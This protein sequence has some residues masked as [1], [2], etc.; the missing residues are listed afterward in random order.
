MG[1]AFL[2]DA[3]IRVGRVSKCNATHGHC[4]LSDLAEAALARII[5]WPVLRLSL[6]RW[7]DRSE[8]RRF[9]QG[10]CCRPASM[11]ALLRGIGNIPTVRKHFQDTLAPEVAGVAPVLFLH[12]E[13]TAGSSVMEYLR[14]QF[15]PDAVDDDPF[16]GAPGHLFC[17]VPADK[18]RYALIWGHQDLPALLRCQPPQRRVVAFFR[19]PHA[20][21]VSLYHFWRALRPEELERSPPHAGIIAARSRSLLGFL[22]SEEPEVAD[23]IDN[24]YA[25]RLAG[26]YRSHG[27]DAGDASLEAAAMA[28]LARVDVVGLVEAMGESLRKL[29][30]A[31]GG[32]PPTIVFHENALSTLVLE[33]GGAFRSVRRQAPTAEERAALDRLTV[34]DRK[35]YAEA[36][37]R[38]AGQAP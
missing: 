37:R 29:A 16:V 11:P 8:V 12:I 28:G 14:V 30:A 10:F 32:A 21:I 26:I 2:L 27:Q 20:R 13:K 38:F 6:G 25:R 23:F 36:K 34:L 3:S 35:I 15:P 19:D 22:D 9:R 17:P 33:P 24:A 18:R 5:A 31:I 1:V 7:P 4:P